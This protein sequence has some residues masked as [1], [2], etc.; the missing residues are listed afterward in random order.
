V[1]V[2]DA[3]LIGPLLLSSLAHASVLLVGVTHLSWPSPPIPIELRPPQPRARTPER[4]PPTPSPPPPSHERSHAAPRATAPRPGAGK[5]QA[6]PPPE[7]AD[8][9]PLAPEGASLVVLLRGD[10]LR[11]SPHRAGVEALL[12]ALPDYQTLLGDTGLSPVDDLD[13]LLIATADPRDVTATFLAA[14]Y[15]DSERLRALASRPLPAGDPR[16]FRSLAPGLTVLVRPEGAERLDAA[17]RGGP[18][19]GGEARW[20][21]ELAQLDRMGAAVDGPSLLVTLSDAPALFRLGGGL[22]TP[23]SLALAATGDAAPAV[24]VRAQFADE[25]EAAA[26]AAAWPD[27]LRRWRTST[28]L[29]GLGPML[30][31]L[32]L[33]HSGAEVELEGRVAATQMTLALS[34]ARALAPPRHVDAPPPVH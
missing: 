19:D 2:R 13:A 4:P 24:R 1:R 32:K 8:L 23:L 30:D 18:V 17:M 22:P 10:K 33:S 26:F 14:R 34:W 29:L 20:L 16:V 12:A 28:G 9:K 21:T 7:T 15:P 27:I 5:P 31:G 11:R 6:P 3:N 25:S